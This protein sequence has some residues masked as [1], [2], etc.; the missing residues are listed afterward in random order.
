MLRDEIVG[1]VERFS[2]S[3]DPPYRAGV[4]VQR[5]EPSSTGRGFSVE[6][7]HAD[8]EAR[9]VVVAVGSH[10]YPNFPAWSEAID[11]D[12]VQLHTQNY[13][14]SAQLPDGAVLVVG[15][16][17]S[18]C[19][20]VED[21]LVAGRDVHLC[22][23]KAGR[24]PRRCRGREIIHWLVDAGLYEMP[25]QEHPMGEAVR[26]KPNAH[27]SGRDGGRTIDLRRLGMDGVRLHGR[28]INAQGTKVSF[29]D[30]LSGN[31]DAIDIECQETLTLVDEY[32]ERNGIDAPESDLEPVQWNPPNA[33]LTLDL[34]EMG[35]NTLIYG[36]GFRYDFSWIDVPIFDRDG[37]PHYERGVTE[38]QGLYF[39]GLHWLHTFGSGLF[40][41]VGRDSKYVVDDLC[42]A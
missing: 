11:K 37:Y 15:S 6:T 5:V 40:Y 41:Q 27:L 21:L 23:G 20:V 9:N 42:R 14:N 7:S 17:Q 8:Y 30:D 29:A 39:V 12:I 19:Q 36:T 16:A 38:S 1:Y 18:G 25:V 33:S 26:F 24:I 34:R 2:R 35:I 28:L 4:D 3:F 10:Q 32:I 31:L 22:V 13:R